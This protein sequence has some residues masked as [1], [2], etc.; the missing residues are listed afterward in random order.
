[1]TESS[2]PKTRSKENTLP[3]VV[4]ERYFLRVGICPPSENANTKISLI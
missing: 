4:T 2:R 3:A 1:M